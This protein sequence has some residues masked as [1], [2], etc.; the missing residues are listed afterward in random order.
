M[1][2]N[3]T[4]EVLEFILET[5]EED[6]LDNASEHHVYFKA[7][8]ALEGEEYAKEYLNNVMERFFEGDETA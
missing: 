6:F 2:K 7:L 5:E 4:V 3:Y 8:A 1:E